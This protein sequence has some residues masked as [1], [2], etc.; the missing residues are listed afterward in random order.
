MFNGM[1]SKFL[2]GAAAAVLAVSAMA[3]MAGATEVKGNAL[4]SDVPAANTHYNAIYKAVDYK[5]LSG[6]PDR[7]FKPHQQLTRAHV[8]KALGKYV[9]A[10]SGKKI[11]DFK[12]NNVKPFNDVTAASPD[13]ELYT[14]SLIVKQAGIFTGDQ[15]NLRPA[16]LIVRQQMAKVLVEAFDLKDLAGVESKVTDN[17]KAYDQAYRNYINILSENGVTTEK[18][19]RP[20]DTTTR[21]QLASFLVRSYDVAHP[22][23]ETAG[24]AVK[25]FE[26]AI[27]DFKDLTADYGVGIVPDGSAKNTYTI[28]LPE[29]LPEEVGG[30]GFFGTLAEQGV[31]TIVI[32]GSQFTVSDGKGNVSSEAKD[33]GKA[34][35]M[36]AVIENTLSVT[37]HVPYGNGD[38]AAA[39][40]Y[41]FNI[42]S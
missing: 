15:N 32:N 12:L 20:V 41:T 40:T 30:T 14:Y 27:G 2:A 26:E 3:P 13:K 4:F 8:V 24:E 35:M 28:T 21:G 38:A 42:A 11:S 29:E 33:A 19:F 22:G 16:N 6:F 10:Q 37:V 34:L 17:A 23:E 5:I 25:E 39:V 7:T 31:Q 9:V 36:A 18:L 1:R